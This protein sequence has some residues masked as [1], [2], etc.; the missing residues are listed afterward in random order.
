MVS[1]DALPKLIE[2]S[3]RIVATFLLAQKIKGDGSSS[4]KAAGNNACLCSKHHGPDESVIPA[5]LAGWIP[6]NP[7]NRVA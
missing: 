5:E 1:M 7:L 4:G 6:G 2:E 3:R